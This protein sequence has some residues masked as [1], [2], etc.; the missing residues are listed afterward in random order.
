MQPETTRNDLPGY[1]TADVWI[2]VGHYSDRGTELRIAFSE[3]LFH[4]MQDFWVPFSSPAGDALGW[5]CFSYVT[6]TRQAAMFAATQ[7]RSA[8]EPAP[9]AQARL[10]LPLALLPA[11]FSPEQ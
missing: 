3:P 5:M 1:E 4:G 8:S 6:T 9:P 11:G 7:W 2:E 10:P